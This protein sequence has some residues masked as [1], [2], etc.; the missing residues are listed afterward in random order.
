[1]VTPVA[2]GKAVSHPTR[3]V[4]NGRG[5]FEIPAASTFMPGVK[6]E[7]CHAVMANSAANRPTHSF[8]PMLPG[9]A[10]RWDA[11]TGVTVGQDS[12]TVCHVESRGDLQDY[13]DT[14]QEEADDLSDTLVTEIAAAKARPE[15]TSSATGTAGNYL[16]AIGYTNNYFY[17]GEGSEGAHNPPYIQAG[18]K[19]GLQLVKSVGGSFALVSA[20]EA[21]VAP[22]TMNAVAGRIVNGDG[23][24][25]AAGTLTLL[26]D[27]T[28]AGTTVSDANG[29]FAFT[30]APAATT[31]YVVRWDRSSNASTQLLSDDETIEV[32]VPLIPTTI[33]I[34]TSS[35]NVLLNGQFTLS[36]AATPVGL[37]GLNMHVD[38]KKPGRAYYSYSS[39]RTIYASGGSARWLYKYIPRLIRGTYVFKAVFDGN[40][41]YGA[42]TSPTTVSVRVR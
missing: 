12:C 38:V 30:V 21:P 17:T 22:S 16:V 2:T 1:V 7:D 41:T 37:V 23:S 28:P 8:K 42:S 40:A 24:G 29:N 10:E 26:A 27:G 32:A 39:A 11:L 18:L 20:P 15:F 4:Y 31:T 34:A 33:T 6:C 13:I 19:K 25:A 35:S 9:D 14:W 36:G 5:M 3:E